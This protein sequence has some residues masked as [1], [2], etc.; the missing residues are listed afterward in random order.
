MSFLFDVDFYHL[1]SSVV[2]NAKRK[3]TKY[4]VDA[5]LVVSVPC[6]M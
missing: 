2:S 3:S 5:R 1:S 6:D 4:V